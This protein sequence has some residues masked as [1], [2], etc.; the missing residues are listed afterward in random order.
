MLDARAAMKFIYQSA[1]I[2]ISLAPDISSA[3]EIR[4]YSPARHDR[5]TADPHAFNPD[6]WIDA[7][8]Y[9]AIGWSMTEPKQQVVLVSPQHFLLPTHWDLKRGEL[10][11]FMAPN[12]GIWSSTIESTTPS[13]SRVVRQ[14]SRS[15][16]SVNPCL[17]VPRFVL[18]L[19]SV[20]HRRTTILVC[21]CRFSGPTIAWARRHLPGLPT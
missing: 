13:G 2:L 19:T 4:D 16:D 9:A 11:S 1:I 10:V 15:G 21:R 5:F 8:D 18:C 20:C 12:G 6:A 14:G 17:T 7:K 3:L